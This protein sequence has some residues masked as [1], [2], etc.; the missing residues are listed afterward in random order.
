[1][2]EKSHRTAACIRNVLTALILMASL[3]M[4]ALGVGA[5]D[6]SKVFRLP[7]AVSENIKQRVTGLI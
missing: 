5:A 7:L 2:E 4:I 3:L 6:L 1:M